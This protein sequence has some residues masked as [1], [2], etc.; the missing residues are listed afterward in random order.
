MCALYYMRTLSH[1]HR[2]W[3]GLHISKQVEDGD[4]ILFGLKMY[5]ILQKSFQ[6]YKIGFGLMYGLK[7][8]NHRV[9]GL[10]P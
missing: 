7:F 9:M 1:Q 10:I 5:E 4:Q 8:L 3:S 6:S 2:S